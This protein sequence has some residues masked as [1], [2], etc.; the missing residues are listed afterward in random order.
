MASINLK[1]KKSLF[2]EAYLP[3]LT[4]YSKRY[5]VLYGGAGSGKSVFIAQKLLVK[6]CKSK[7][8]I[9][10]LRKFATTLRDSV[11]QLMIDL[12]KKWHLYEHCVINLSTYTIIL[13]N[14]SV[15]LFKGLDDSEKIK[16]ITDITDAWIEESSEVTEDDYTQIDLRIRALVADLQLYVSFNPVSKANWVYKKWFDPKN[17]TYDK[18]E[19][20]ILRTTYKDNRFLP[21]AYIKALEEKALSNP[22]YYKIYALGE[23]AVA[24][25]LVITNWTKED[26]NPMELAKKY[27]HRVGMDLGFVDPSAVIETLY[28]RDNK[29]IYVF[30][31][32]YKKG[33]QLGELAQAIFDMGLRKVKIMVDA[34]EPRSRE[35]FRN[36]G[37]NAQPCIKGS[38]S[39]KAGLMFLQD[40]HIV[41]HP[42]CTNFITE[43]ENFSYIKSKKTGEWT[44]DTTHEW[45]HAIDACR[46]AYS[47]VYTQKKAKTMSK[48]ALG[49]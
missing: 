41:V 38:D 27:E 49:L 9:L 48:S 42:S 25:G 21:K 8:K 31:E 35:Y 22:V 40:H 34:A 23:F 29:T 10:I 39:V 20:F 37:I 33:C 14:E 13:P 45:S 44:D 24:E 4:D 2:N 6:A 46:Y 26:F 18:E 32:F 19:T 5:N 30:A 43:L 11:F 47:D 16:S 1:L 17:A 3:Y 7:R 36:K 12:L 28:D 15:F